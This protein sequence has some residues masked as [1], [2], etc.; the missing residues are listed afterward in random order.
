MKLRLSTY[1]LTGF[2][3][4]V[5]RRG[6][7]LGVR[8]IISTFMHLAHSV[9]T[10]KLPLLKAYVKKACIKQSVGKI[11]VRYLKRTLMQSMGERHSN[12]RRSERRS[13]FLS[14]ELS[15]AQNS[16]VER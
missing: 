8:S 12:E 4:F 3:C 9:A 11:S 16:Q 6:V 15:G 10:L 13:L 2:G 14:A 7:I 1:G 5:V